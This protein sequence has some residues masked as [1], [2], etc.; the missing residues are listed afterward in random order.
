MEPK[1]SPMKLNSNE[2]TAYTV[3]TNIKNV[4]SYQN[5]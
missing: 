5:H 2:K 4:V 3:A 1:Y